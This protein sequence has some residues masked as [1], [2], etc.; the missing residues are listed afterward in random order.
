MV[1]TIEDF[2]ERVLARVRATPVEVA[3]LP[4]YAASASLFNG[5][6][7]VAFF[8]HEIA[9]WRDDDGEILVLG[10]RWCAA[11]REAPPRATP[12]A[13]ENDPL[14]FLLGEGA[15]SY[16][17]ALFS[18]RDDDHAGV[19]AAVDRMGRAAACQPQIRRSR[20]M[21][22][23]GGAAGIVRATSCLEARLPPV[24]GYDASRC[25]LRR[26][27][28]AAIGVLL[29]RY[30]Y[31]VAP[32]P[33]ELL[34]FAHGIAGE[35]WALVEALGADHDLVRRRLSELASFREL[36]EEGLVYWP[37]NK[38]T[39][40]GSLLETLCHGM[41]GHTLLWCEVARQSADEKA[42]EF[43]RA[44][45]ETTAV[46]G[47]ANPTLCCGLVGQ[48][49]ALQRYAEVS[50]DGRFTR[51]AAARL[52]RAIELAG[53]ANDLPLLGLWGGMLGIALVALGR[54][55]GEQALPCLEAP[56]RA[57]GASGSTP[58]RADA[59]LQPFGTEQLVR[60]RDE[61]ANVRLSRADRVGNLVIG[62]ALEHEHDDA[63][64]S[65]G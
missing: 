56:G 5:A 14:R 30:E 31:P 21:E 53:Q 54:L 65:F 55:H 15:L 34:G 46:L 37:P 6:A 26:V 47:T 63:L 3:L 19:V 43:A 9:R 49:V 25:V 50:G 22:L 48:A 64:N 42:L 20:A 12:A 40:D 52:R 29:E 39:T 28:E 7:G 13:R 38:V 36:D 59:T 11:A 60:L 35:A 10:R 27:R 44:C 33:N 57:V 45:A 23:F 17:E 32:D 51:R 62:A 58:A 1:P 4:P 8:L 18:L 61:Q 41:P 24:T 16:V 2:V